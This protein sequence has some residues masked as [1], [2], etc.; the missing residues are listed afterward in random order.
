MNKKEGGSATLLTIF[1]SAIIITIGI[2]FNWIVKEHLKSAEGLKLK[3]EAMLNAYSTFDT[4]MYLILIGKKTQKEYVIQNG[5][6]YFAITN[7]PLN[8]EYV[9]AKNGVQISIRDTSGMLSLTSLN[10]SALERLIELHSGEDA[11]G[12]IAGYLDWVDRDKLVRING[13][14]D[15]EYNFKGL[16]Y[17]TRNYPIQYKEEFSFI[18]GMNKE[19]YKKI[20]Q[21]I[22]ILP[23]AGFNV[24]TAPEAVLK[25]YLDI[26]ETA[27]KSLLDYISRKP[28]SSDTEL[29]GMTGRRIVHDE[30]V[31]FYPSPFMEITIRAGLPEPIYTIHVGIDTRQNLNFPYSVIYWREE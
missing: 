29:F 31:Y 26:D 6:E 24:N 16:P 9:T 2:G 19:L 4:L 28:I 5:E 20:E 18:K 22:T 30:G 23:S 11:A 25:A 17:S 12:I 10:E 7:I 1:L 14:E 27:V 21:Y 3:S 13:A 8:G 15:A